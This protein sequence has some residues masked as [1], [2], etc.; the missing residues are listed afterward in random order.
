MALQYPTMMSTDFPLLH[1]LSILTDRVEGCE[2]SEILSLL[3]IPFSIF[4]PFVNDHSAKCNVFGPELLDVMLG[5]RELA[6]SLHFPQ[7]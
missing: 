4:I 1:E 7:K 6:L 3:E 5:N 2:G